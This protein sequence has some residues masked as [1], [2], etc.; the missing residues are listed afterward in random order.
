[1]AYRALKDYPT[2][3]KIDDQPIVF[4]IKRL[5]ADEWLRFQLEYRHNEKLSTAA[6]LTLQPRND[7]ERALASALEIKAFR[8]RSLSEAERSAQE[9][10]EKA[11]AERGNTFA[12][13][14]IRAFVTVDPDQVFDEGK[15]QYVTSGEDLVEIFGAST[16]VLSAL[17]QE[18]F[19]QNYL[20]TEQK[21]R[22][23]LL[24]DSMPGLSEPQMAAGETPAATATD[25]VPE[26]SAAPAAAMGSLDATS[27]GATG[28]S[29]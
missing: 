21:K 6:K 26:A 7:E 1:M 25:A 23:R 12:K 22:L 3:L 10:E 24:R 15:G 4:R 19:L 8:W 17:V 11:S 5:S 29:S 20:S 14:T 2:P 13:E 18:V 28:P 16:D 27:S 9:A